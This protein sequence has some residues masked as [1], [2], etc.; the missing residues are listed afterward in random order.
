M[1][2]IAPTRSAREHFSVRLRADLATANPAYLECA[3]TSAT[4]ASNVDGSH[5]AAAAEKQC[6]R[7]QRHSRND[8]LEI[9]ANAAGNESAPRA[10]RFDETC[11]RQ[12]VAKQ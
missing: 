4:A 10:G 9:G 6:F 11:Q 3:N 1:S 5:C 2:T 7:L 8:T 12:F